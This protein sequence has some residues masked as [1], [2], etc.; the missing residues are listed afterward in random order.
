VQSEEGLDGGDGGR[1]VSGGDGAAAL[2]ALLFLL[3]AVAVARDVDDDGCRG[4]TAATLGRG[5]MGV[6]EAVGDG[7][8]VLQAAGQEEGAHLFPMGL[9]EGLRTNDTKG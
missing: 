3:L 4:L 9:K 7:V 8:L 6:E 1:R 5:A 2:L